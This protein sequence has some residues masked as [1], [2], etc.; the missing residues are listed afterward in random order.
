MERLPRGPL[1]ELM[2]GTAENEPVPKTLLLEELNGTDEEL[3]GI[4]ELPAPQV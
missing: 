4:E 1:E 3:E 2:D